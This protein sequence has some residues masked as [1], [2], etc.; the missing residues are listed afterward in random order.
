MRATPATDRVRKR[1]PIATK[2][3]DACFAHIVEQRDRVRA[4]IEKATTEKAT[5]KKRSEVACAAV[6][7][8]DMREPARL[9]SRLIR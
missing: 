3:Q 8:K 5:A 1:P 6:A 9:R 7:L 4:G 2:L